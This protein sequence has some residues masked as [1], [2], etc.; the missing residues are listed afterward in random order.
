MSD[1]ILDMNHI[2]KE[3]AGVKALDDVNFQVKRGEIHALCGETGAAQ[4]T[5]MHVLSGVYPYGT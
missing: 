5:L 3:F 4:S 2:T 1:I